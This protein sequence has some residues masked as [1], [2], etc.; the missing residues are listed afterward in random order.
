MRKL[1]L[2]LLS[3]TALAALVVS[4][5]LSCTT[6]QVNWG[7]HT[8]TLTPKQPPAHLILDAVGIVFFLPGEKGR[9]GITGTAFAVE[10]DLILTAGHVCQKFEEK[11]KEGLAGSIAVG[12]TGGHGL[13]GGMV[14]AHVIKWSMEPDVC[15]LASPGHKMSV[16]PIS[17]RYKSVRSGDPVLLPG[18]PGGFFPVTRDGRVSSVFAYAHGPN[19]AACLLVDVVAEGGN[20]GSPVIWNGEVIGMLVRVPQHPKNAALAVTSMSLLDFI[21]SAFIED[22]K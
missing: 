21:E 14:E 15:L 11:K 13:P 1:I 12:V 10:K 8:V 18:A 9:S 19:N 2:A 16:L 17:Q 7:D 3:A 6:S 22:G 5:C 20:S 4:S